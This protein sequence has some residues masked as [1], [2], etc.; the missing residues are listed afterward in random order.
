MALYAKEIMQRAS[1]ILQDGG[2]VRW[3]LIELLKWLNDGV[4]EIVNLKPN[5]VTEFVEIALDVGT[6]QTLA[7]DHLNL[8]RVT[9]NLTA[10]GLAPRVGKSA[11]TPI[12]ADLMNAQMPGWQDPTVLAYSVDVNHVIQDMAA[13]REFYVVP[14]NTGF[15]VIEA[16]VTVMPTDLAEPANPLDIESYAALAVSVPDQFRAALVDYILVRAFSKDMAIAG[17]SQRAVQHQQLFDRALGIQRQT[18]AETT[19]NKS[20]SQPNS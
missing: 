14:G 2:L 1:T 4:R 15:G 11:I 3:P 18:D 13:P 16:L 17:N 6:L 5:E 9:R 10:A 12:S 20:G 8:W 7:A 19:V